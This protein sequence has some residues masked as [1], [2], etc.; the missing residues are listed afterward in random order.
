MNTITLK[1]KILFNPN[2][3]TKKHV[4]QSSWKKIA[5]IIFEHDVKKDESFKGICN[6]YA[7]FIRKRFNLI[8]NMPLRGPHISFI[9]DSMRDLMKSGKS[10]EEVNSDWN[11]LKEKWNGKEI[12]IELDI[13][14]RTDGRTWWLNVPQDKRQQLHDIRAEVGLGRPFFGL[15]MS[16]GY[17]R[18]GHE[19]HAQ[20]IHRLIEQ[21]FIN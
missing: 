18:D 13:D 8:L 21:N 7:W 12:E 2:D 14:P 11:K 6:Y 20:Y 1:G 19:E 5:M 17:I 4:N 9:N 10:E 15:H 16:I 3:K